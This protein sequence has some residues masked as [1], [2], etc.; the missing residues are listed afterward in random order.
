MN[1]IVLVGEASDAQ[2]ALTA[3]HAYIKAPFGMSR[4]DQIWGVGGGFKYACVE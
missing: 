2:A 3:A 1:L 4:L